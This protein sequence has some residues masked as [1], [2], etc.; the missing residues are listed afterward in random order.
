MQKPNAPATKRQ[1]WA[2]FCATKK[3]VRNAGL[4]KQE[5]SGIISAGRQSTSY[6]LALTGRRA[7]TRFVDKKG[8]L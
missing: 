7:G 2:I 4:T 1:T 6:I 3:D 8:R 5:A